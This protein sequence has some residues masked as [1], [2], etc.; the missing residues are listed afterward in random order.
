MRMCELDVLPDTVVDYAGVDE[1]YTDNEPGLSS[2]STDIKR[3][4]PMTDG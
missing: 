4:A 1:T 3:T 2:C